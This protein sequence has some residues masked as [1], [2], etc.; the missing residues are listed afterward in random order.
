MIFVMPLSNLMIFHGLDT[1][2][3]TQEKGKSSVAQCP[4]GYFKNNF[5]ECI[6]IREK[7]IENIC[8]NKNCS[9]VFITL[10]ITYI[11]IKQHA[12]NQ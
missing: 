7:R 8:F 6:Y 5:L 11:N 10:D 9:T 4:T 1:L 3:L 12:S 2:Q